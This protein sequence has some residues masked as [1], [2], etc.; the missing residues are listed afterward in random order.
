MSDGELRS[1]LDEKTPSRKS[2]MIGIWLAQVAELKD[3]G[4]ASHSRYLG[5]GGFR[6]RMRRYSHL[7]LNLWQALHKSRLARIE[8]GVMVDSGW[9]EC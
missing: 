2:A 6:T 3:A 7:G 4:T 8:G 5:S 9:G 1:R